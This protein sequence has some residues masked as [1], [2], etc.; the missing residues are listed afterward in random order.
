MDTYRN[1]DP[2]HVPGPIKNGIPAAI[3]II[4]ALIIDEMEAAGLNL[5]VLIAAVLTATASTQ[6]NGVCNSCNCQFNNIQV[7]DQLVNTKIANTIG[8]LKCSLILTIVNLDVLQYS[9]MLLVCSDFHSSL[10]Q[11][12]FVSMQV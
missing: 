11:H 8:K 10:M 6:G 2:F 1:D 12:L 7:L 4:Y 5:I 3:D 9:Y